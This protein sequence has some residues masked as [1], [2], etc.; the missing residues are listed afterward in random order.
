MRPSVA[1]AALLLATPVA[2]AQVADTSLKSLVDAELAFAKLASDSNV[3]VA[4]LANLDTGA[5]AFLRD[6]MVHM[7]PLWER[8]PAGKLALTWYPVVARVAR[9]GDLGY[10][11][12]PYEARPGGA[13]DTSVGHGYYFTIWRRLPGQSRWTAVIDFGTGNPAPARAPAAWR[14]PR[15][16]PIAQ[17]VATSGA[18][19]ARA[20]LFAADSVVARDAIKSGAALAVVRASHGEVR[21]HRDGME[22]S[23]GGHAAMAWIRQHGN[24]AS[25]TPLGGEISRAGDFGYT[26]GSWRDAKGDPKT[27]H[28][29]YVRVWLREGGK[30]RIVEDVTQ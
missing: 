19:V 21:L 13:A 29:Y 6:S 25:F 30:W 17:G 12:G 3:K 28:G 15:L 26:Y 14:S 2:G 10:T 7:R 11:T 23:L 27:G 20:S 8:R 1:I 22:P 4:F 9:S 16:T 18:S 5:I 24:G